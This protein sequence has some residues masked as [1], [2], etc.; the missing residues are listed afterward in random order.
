MKI[1]E[2]IVLVKAMQ[3]CSDWSRFFRTKLQY[4]PDLGT[5]YVLL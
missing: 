5:Y 3:N 1:S 2:H 4:F